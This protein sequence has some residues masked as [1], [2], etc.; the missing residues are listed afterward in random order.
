[1][2]FLLEALSICQH[3]DLINDVLITQKLYMHFGVTIKCKTYALE[4]KRTNEPATEIV[5]NHYIRFV[6]D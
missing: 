1:M 4:S 2:H 5:K 6:N 3:L